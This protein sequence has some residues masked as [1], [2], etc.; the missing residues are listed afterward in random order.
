M[1]VVTATY[2][3][4]AIFA[5]GGLFSILAAIFGWEWFFTSAN[6]R[7]LT[8]KMSRMSARVLYGLI[9]AAIISMAVYLCYNVNSP[10]R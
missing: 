10:L 5:A 3:L 8:G 9:G 6:V 1:S 2:I 4:A 7:I